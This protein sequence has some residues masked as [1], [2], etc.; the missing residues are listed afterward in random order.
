MF[1]EQ[2]HS[3]CCVELLLDCVY[4]VY[5]KHMNFKFNLGPILGPKISYHV[6]KATPKYEKNYKTCNNCRFDYFVEWIPNL[7]LINFSV[8]LRSV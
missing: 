8:S 7:Y 2:T 3:K 1:P 6:Y 5:V 4:I